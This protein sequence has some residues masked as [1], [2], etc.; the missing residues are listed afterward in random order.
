MKVINRML[1]KY[2]YSYAMERHVQFYYEAL[3][4]SRRIIFSE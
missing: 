4:K 2:V 3:N 1:L